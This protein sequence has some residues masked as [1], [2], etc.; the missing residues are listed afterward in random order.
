MWLL[1]CI[2]FNMVTGV[3]PFYIDH[4]N[5]EKDD[6]EIYAHI[7]EGRWREKL[8]QYH[9]NASIN[10]LQILEVCFLP[11]P[12]ERISSSAII[13]HPYFQQE[14]SKYKDIPVKKVTEV[15]MSCRHF[16][17]RHFFQKEVLRHMGS[18][19]ITAQRKGLFAQNFRRS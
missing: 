2:I 13:Q 6:T 15:F 5:F 4:D 16:K 11:L 19:F 18:R 12:E 14:N 10:L 8:N 17:P 1:G 7:R 3:P 9:E